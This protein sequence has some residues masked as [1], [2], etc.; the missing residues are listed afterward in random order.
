MLPFTSVI[1]NFVACLVS[2]GMA[3]SFI[4]LISSSGTSTKCEAAAIIT[5]AEVII[6]EYDAEYDAISPLRKHVIADNTPR[7]FADNG[8]VGR[9][10][11]GLPS[12]AILVS[13]W[14]SMSY[15]NIRCRYV[16]SNAREDLKT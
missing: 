2:L 3:F 12:M 7:E 9:G 16:C 13:C 8:W 11:G 1:P 15:I 14:D 6:A 10:L 4:K 5:S